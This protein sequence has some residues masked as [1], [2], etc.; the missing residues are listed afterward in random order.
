MTNSILQL[1]SFVLGKDID[2]LIDESLHD[3]TLS[4]K[5]YS[6]R[7]HLKYLK[8]RKKRKFKHKP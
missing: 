7:Q 8:L 3:I 4:F 6:K 2:S 5:I 1:V